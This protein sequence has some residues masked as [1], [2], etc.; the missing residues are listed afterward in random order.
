MLTTLRVAENKVPRSSEYIPPTVRDMREISEGNCMVI[1]GS[2]CESDPRS[3]L[4]VGSQRSFLFGWLG[5]FQYTN[6]FHE[7]IFVSQRE[8]P[9]S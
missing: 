5:Q 6:C 7:S 9:L 4:R 8:A 3:L 1:L 2:W